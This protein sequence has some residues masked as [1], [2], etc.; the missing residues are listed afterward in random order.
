[1]F[2]RRKKTSDPLDDARFAPAG[3]ETVGS[4]PPSPITPG[5][6]GS[7]GVGRLPVEASFTITG[8][9]TVVTGTIESGTLQ[10]G[11][12]VVIERAGQVVAASRIVAI[13]MTRKMIDTAQA[14]ETVGVLLHGVSRTEVQQGDL[15]VATG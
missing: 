5:A 15:L 12:Q 14:G 2:W 7:P 6:S 8:R 4:T 13:E 10:V 1:M 9:G 3:A 11:H